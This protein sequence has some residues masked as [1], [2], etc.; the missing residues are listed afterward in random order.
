MDAECVWAS[1]KSFG[2]VRQRADRVKR[3]CSSTFALLAFKTLIADLIFS[4]QHS[5]CT[6]KEHASCSREFY[7]IA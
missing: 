4:A 7:I 1:T 6:T 3:E 5:G 2:M